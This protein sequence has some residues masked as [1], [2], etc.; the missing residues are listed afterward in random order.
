MVLEF[1]RGY[2]LT[3]PCVHKPNSCSKTVRVRL[4]FDPITIQWLPEL[5]STVVSQGEC[6]RATGDVGDSIL[7]DKKFKGGWK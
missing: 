5:F 2:G 4:R 3:A 6:I 1:R 7:K